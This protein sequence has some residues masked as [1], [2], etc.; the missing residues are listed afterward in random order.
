MQ[1]KRWLPVEVRV[2]RDYAPFYTLSGLA[3]ILDRTEG[4]VSDKARQIGV[5]L[6]HTAGY[7]WTADE[8]EFLEDTFADYPTEKLAKVLG[9]SVSAVN[10]KASRMGLKKSLHY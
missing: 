9:R 6:V 3:E 1:G 5:S 4:A 2:L 10:N 8:M 7:R